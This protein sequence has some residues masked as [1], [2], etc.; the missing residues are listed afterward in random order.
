MKREQTIRRQLR[1]FGMLREA[2]GAMKS[3]S[4]H[5]FR[6]A[7]SALLASREY[8]TGIDAIAGEIGFPEPPQAP[9]P[10]A[11]L[12]VA[13]DLGLCDGYNMRL[14]EEAIRQHQAVGY[15]HIYCIGRRTGPAL[16]RAQMHPSKLYPAPTSVAGLTGMLMT[17]AQ[18]VLSGYFQEAFGSLDVVFSRF[19]G[20]GEFTP[21]CQRILP[22]EPRPGNPSRCRRDYV[23]PRHLMAVALRE[24]L[25]ITLFQI[26]LE[27]LAS[28]HGARLVA[29]EAAGEWLDARLDATQRQFMAI[30]QESATQ[31][32]LDII[33]GTP[34]IRES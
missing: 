13:S 17:L 25:Y 26:L 31:E 22:V 9:G 1:S 11:L 12:L 10:A 14:A 28:E 8:K 34:R 32:L 23:S 18:D 19:E 15:A 7:R 27:A 24:L 4:A 3:L 21:V 6:V 2:V 29:T 33:A 5:H 16:Q 30:R 20:V